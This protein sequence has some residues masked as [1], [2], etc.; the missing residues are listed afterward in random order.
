MATGLTAFAGGLAGLDT[1]TG[2]VKP[3]VAGTGLVCLGT[4]ANTVANTSGSD[5]PL[6]GS[7]AVVVILKREIKV[8]WF[9]NDGTNPVIATTIGSLVYGIDDQTVSALATSRSAVGIAW[10]IDTNLGVAVEMT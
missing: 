8:V 9:K 6:V 3:F 5:S 7:G 2:K 4:F 10:K 1:S